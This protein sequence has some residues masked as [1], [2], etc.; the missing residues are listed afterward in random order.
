MENLSR[1]NQREKMKPREILEE[2]YWVMCDID[3][4]ECSDYTDKKIGFC[5]KYKK[6][7]NETLTKLSECVLSEEEIAQIIIKARNRDLETTKEFIEEVNIIKT[8]HDH[9]KG[10][11]KGE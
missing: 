3:C 8:I 9:I 10:L 7:I 5:G 6:D 11:F 1:G 4:G 2:I